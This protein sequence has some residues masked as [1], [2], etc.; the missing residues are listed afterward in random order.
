[1]MVMVNDD[2]D[3]GYHELD[4]DDKECYQLDGEE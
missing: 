2:G 1:M 3:Q 4:N